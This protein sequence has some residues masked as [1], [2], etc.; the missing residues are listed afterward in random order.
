MY[1]RLAWEGEE[2]MI[3]HLQFPFWPNYGVVQNLSDLA[4]FVKKVDVVV[5]VDGHRTIWTLMVEVN[6]D[7][8]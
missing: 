5:V 1:Y 7:L 2:R 8:Y 6:L 4:D 3:E